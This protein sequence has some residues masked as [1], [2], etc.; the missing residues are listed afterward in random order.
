MLILGHYLAVVWLTNP[1]R[2]PMFVFLGWD[3][4]ERIQIYQQVPEGRPQQITAAEN[5]VVDFAVAP[6][7][8]SI[9][10]STATVDGSSS[11]WLI[12]ED[13]RD[14]RLILTCPQAECSQPVWAPDNRRVILEERNIGDDGIP[15]SPRL[16]WL[17][18]KTGETKLV[19]D[20][21]SARGSG[22]RFSQD[23]QWLSYFSPEEEGAVIYNFQDG[24]TRIVAD[25]I[26]APLAWSPVTNQIVVP[27][28]DLVILHGDEG[29]DHQQHTH[30]Y[31]SAVHLFMK[32]SV[33]S[34]SHNISGSLKVEDS[35]PAWSPNEEWIAFGRRFSGTAAGRQLWL[36]RPDGS[37]SRA[38]TYDYSINYGPPKWSPD[39]RY[40]LFQR[41]DTDE[42]DSD[43]SI[44]LLDTETGQ[45]KELVS[46]GMQPAWLAR[47][48]SP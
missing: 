28:L 5:G 1:N 46:S 14:P 34:E 36:M 37:E 11:L 21:S 15:G 48:A 43:P 33:D 29:E 26:G 47:A 4:N 42:P 23:G 35:V 2:L 44:W 12:D 27:N 13:G 41:F 10:Y 24:E 32:D 38:L 31:E 8:K 25:E 45:E 40:L 39:S 18:S 22:V 17:D 16:L 9:I 7:G 30:D 19:L 3:E 6:D 20:E